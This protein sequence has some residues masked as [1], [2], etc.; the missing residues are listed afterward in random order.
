[1]RRRKVDAARCGSEP[2]TRSLFLAMADV[3]RRAGGPGRRKAHA[4][5][6]QLSSRR[7]AWA[8]EARDRHGGLGD[9]ACGLGMRR[10]QVRRAERTSIFRK[11]TFYTT[12]LFSEAEARARQVLHACDCSCSS[13][14]WR[15]GFKQERKY[16]VLWNRAS[17]WRLI[18]IP[19][20]GRKQ[21]CVH[22][23]FDGFSTLLFF[24]T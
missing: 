6:T 16:E 17:Q 22:K 11:A 13:R 2:W 19:T 8:T 10:K 7:V 5:A 18:R 15:R 14:R 24:C 12:A 9:W 1:M 4:R 21:P 23:R 3:L 20:A